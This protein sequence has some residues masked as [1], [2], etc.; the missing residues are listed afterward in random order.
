M[1]IE[2][3]T[4]LFMFSCAS[5]LAAQ[6]AGR[7]P[8]PNFKP[9]NVTSTVIE[10]QGIGCPGGTA[11]VSVKRDGKEL[12]V[13][14]AY[15]DGEH[16]A[17]RIELASAL[18]EQKDALR[19]EKDVEVSYQLRCGLEQHAAAVATLKV[20]ADADSWIEINGPVYET[21][22]SITG[23][24][25][26]SIKKVR[27]FLL[28]PSPY[29][30]VDATVKAYY[31]QMLQNPKSR[32]NDLKRRQE[33][34]K[35]KPEDGEPKQNGGEQR[36]PEKAG[37]PLGDLLYTVMSPERQKTISMLEGQPP[38]SSQD[39]TTKP[40]PPPANRQQFL[41][42]KSDQVDKTP[43]IEESRCLLGEEIE[44]LDVHVT[45]D[46]K[47]EATP[48][49]GLEYGECIVVQEYAHNAAPG[50]DSY[51]TAFIQ[52]SDAT[53]GRV[54]GTFTA[55]AAIGQSNGNFTAAD[56]YLS[57]Y[58]EGDL[59]NHLL[60]KEGQDH[61]DLSRFGFGFHYF[62]EGRLN[63]TAVSLPSVTDPLKASTDQ[64]QSLWLQGG[65]YFPV[66]FGGW[67]WTLHGRL[68]TWTL[69]PLAKFGASYVSDGVVTKQVDITLPAEPTIFRGTLDE[70]TKTKMTTTKQS[71]PFYG[72]GARLGFYRYDLIGKHSH[73]GQIAP[74]LL[75]YVDYIYGQDTALRTPFTFE[76]DVVIDTKVASGVTYNTTRTT[77]GYR[78]DQRHM[79][80]GRIKLPYVPFLIGVDASFGT[81][82]PDTVPSVVRFIVA[83]RVDAASA[84]GKIFPKK[85]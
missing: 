22:P 34:G 84:I 40:A 68:H 56:P 24:A 64:R 49:H 65:I 48:A 11:T 31:A 44:R 4:C 85:K 20:G 61:I 23:T 30:Y 6:S 52:S 54:R 35:L 47:W 39:A 63:Q 1:R 8:A 14:A 46:H 42:R 13:K 29:R 19:K 62:A 41:P 12:P 81:G 9:L 18:G 33:E 16:G 25:G 83:T 53:W 7:I 71:L 78:T 37:T 73:N 26:P 70:L 36:K 3:W 43:E 51:H 82:H 21:Q 2:R 59:A 69:G 15:T 32:P 66:R 60:R 67:D 72:G 57:F 17:I 74:E 76:R 58:I 10:G 38:A 27:V 77:T 5:F 45:D 28:S 50:S 80:E 75:G 79:L 55:G